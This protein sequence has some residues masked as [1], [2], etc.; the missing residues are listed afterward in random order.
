MVGG[1]GELTSNRMTCKL[2]VVGNFHG[3]GKL[4]FEL[5]AKWFMVREIFNGHV[6]RLR[7]NGFV[8][9]PLCMIIPTC[10]SCHNI[11]NTC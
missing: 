8:T 4:G 2:R 6:G 9:V 7:C 3:R 5:A 1:G 10:T 11:P